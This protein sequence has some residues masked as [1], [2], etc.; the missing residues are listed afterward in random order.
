VRLFSAVWPPEPALAH[1]ERAVDRVERPAGVRRVPTD[2]WHLTLAFYGNDASLPERA[3]YLDE[4][5]AGLAP[6][7]LRLAGAGTFAGVLWVGVEP[8]TPTDR[9][10]LRAVAAAAGA[11]RKFRPHI[12]VARWRLDRPGRWMADQLA[13]YRGAVWTA[14]QVDLVR[15]DLGAGYRTVHSV[16]LTPW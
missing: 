12:T 10:S 1:L 9:E 3:G 6:P 16:P 4:R 15:S 5:L 7:A 11:G 13:G 2:K 14:S 8:A